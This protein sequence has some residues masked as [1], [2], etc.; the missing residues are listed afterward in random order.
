[1]EREHLDTAIPVPGVDH[2][3]LTNGHGLYAMVCG[4]TSRCAVQIM[5]LAADPRFDLRKTYFLEDGICGGDPAEAPLVS[6]LLDVERLRV[7]GVVGGSLFDR[8][9]AGLLE[10]GALAVLLV[11]REAAH[12]A[13]QVCRQVRDLPRVPL[14]ARALLDAVEKRLV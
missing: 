2:P 7:D 4:T 6:L 5:A 14:P 12:D 3:L 11:G 8:F 10:L 1:M 9:G 13:D